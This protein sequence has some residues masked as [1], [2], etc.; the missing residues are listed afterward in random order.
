M[1]KNNLSPFIIAACKTQEQLENYI[2]LL[3][4]NKLNEFKD[5]EIRFELNPL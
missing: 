3:E 1:H 5:Y 4:Q 2:N